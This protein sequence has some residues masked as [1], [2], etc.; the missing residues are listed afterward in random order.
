MYKYL[1]VFK[2]SLEQYFIY[3]LNFIFW[4]ISTIL[5][6]LLTY[7]LWDSL[8]VKKT[9]ILS[10]TKEEMITY[11]L[12]SSIIGTFVLSGR[13]ADLA[14]EILNG[15]IINYLTKPISF[16]GYLI[17]KELANKTL[18][19]LFG[20]TEIVILIVLFQ[21][22]VFIQPHLSNYGILLILIVIGAA[23]SFL[24][25]FLLSLVAFWSNE[26]WA[27]RFIYTVVVWVLAGTLFPLDIL[28]KPI[29]LLF[30]LTP[31][32]YLLYLPTKIYIEGFSPEFL[33]FIAIACAWIGILFVV[34]RSVW[35]KGLKEF[36]FFG[37]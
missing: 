33:P 8:Y 7:F 32:P 24:I 19:L 35:H 14:A 3:R 15:T 4:R 22:S 1:E 12:L 36:T 2:K 17:A 20:I 16:T 28:P 25:S 27:P 6:I 11:I 21:P 31:F 37:K 26:V 30:M 10:Y 5:S 29:Y 13:V 18:N 34:T 23:L 9:T